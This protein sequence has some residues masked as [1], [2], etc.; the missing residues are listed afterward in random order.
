[1]PV[2]N[3]CRLLSYQRCQTKPT[4][5]GC[6]IRKGNII[7]PQDFGQDRRDC[8]FAATWWANQQGE[9][10][11]ANVQSQTVPEPLT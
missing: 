9:S 6:Q 1:M 5:Q 10:L 8:P 2:R 4:S 3:N 7:T 11:L